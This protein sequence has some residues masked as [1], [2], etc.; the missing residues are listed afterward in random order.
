MNSFNQVML[1]EF[2]AWRRVDDDDIRVNVLQAKWGAFLLDRGRSGG[3]I[4]PDTRTRTAKTIRTFLGAKQNREE[5]VDLRSTEW[6]PGGALYWVN[7]ADVVIAPTTR[8]SSIP[9]PR[10]HG[11]G[12]GTNRPP[13][14]IPIGEDADRVVRTR[15]A[16]PPSGRS[17][18]GWCRKWCPLPTCA[19]V[20]AR[21]HPLGGETT[22]GHPG[23]AKAI[24]IRA[25]MIAHGGR[26]I[27]LHYPQLTNPLT[28]T[29]M[30]S[31]GAHPTSCGDRYATRGVAHISY[32]VSGVALS[33]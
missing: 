20:L 22:P 30:T 23:T 1:D 9:T 18:S 31:K 11:L 12:A 3:S 17:R 16:C 32:A 25:A 2:A 28:K 8:R 5:A 29:E 26:D 27:P 6:A 14:R 33:R 15:R 10:T 4:C 19:P 21:S 7:E 24:W 13:R